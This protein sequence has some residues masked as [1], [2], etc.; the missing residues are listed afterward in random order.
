[1]IA[2]VD[3]GFLFFREKKNRLTARRRKIS[4]L[5]QKSFR[6]LQNELLSKIIQEKAPNRSIIYEQLKS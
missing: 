1:V 6:K 4:F 3:L 2:I 5:F